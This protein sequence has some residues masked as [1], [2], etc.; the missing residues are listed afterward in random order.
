MIIKNFFENKEKI[1]FNFIFN[2]FLIYL[3]NLIIIFERKKKRAQLKLLTGK[4]EKSSCTF[5]KAFFL[6]S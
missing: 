3:S 6:F 4:G 5:L 1:N 2:F